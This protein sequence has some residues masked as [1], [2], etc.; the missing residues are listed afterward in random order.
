[1]RTSI[2]EVKGIIEIEQKAYAQIPTHFGAPDI[3]PGCQNHYEITF[4][5]ASE[6]DRFDNKGDHNF[7]WSQVR[8]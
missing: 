1:M 2:E 5:M 8:A 4:K 7:M 6:K 3:A